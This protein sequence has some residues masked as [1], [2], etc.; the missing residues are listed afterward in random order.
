MQ[1]EL[2]ML[3]VDRCKEADI[4]QHNAIILLYW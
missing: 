4:D 1:Y 2:F 3:W